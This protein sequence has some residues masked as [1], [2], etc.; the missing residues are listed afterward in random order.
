MSIKEAKL[1]PTKPLVHTVG[2]W[3]FSLEPTIIDLYYSDLIL[4]QNMYWLFMFLWLQSFEISSVM[5]NQFFLW[6]ENGFD[7]YPDTGTGVNLTTQA[8]T[9]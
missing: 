6:L 5:I 4:T 1:D 3:T 9:L 2:I 7:V 8:W